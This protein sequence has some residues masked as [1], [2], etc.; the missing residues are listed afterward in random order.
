M[1]VVSVRTALLLAITFTAGCGESP[2][3]TSPTVSPF[4]TQF[5][6]LWNGALTL[7]ASGVSG[8]ECVGTDLQAA[9]PSIDVGTVS[10]TQKETDVSAVVRSATTGLSCQYD[11]AAGLAKVALNSQSCNAEIAFQC[12]NGNT[13]LLDPVGST[14]TATQNDGAINGV[15]ASTFNVFSVDSQGQK[16]PVAGLT[17]RELFTAVRR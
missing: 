5:D 4:V 12:S 17:T 1:K 13:R 7:S 16:K 15:V 8:G 2:I 14:L 6:G 9:G 11:G 3:P 10:I